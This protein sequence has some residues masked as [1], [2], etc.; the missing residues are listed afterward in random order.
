MLQPSRLQ[1]MIE[2]KKAKKS[3][4]SP[5]S[6]C[7]EIR[8]NAWKQAEKTGEKGRQAQS[9]RKKTANAGKKKGAGSGKNLK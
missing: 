8:G 4:E 2:H 6:N 1:W 9:S 5:A 7:L 3:A